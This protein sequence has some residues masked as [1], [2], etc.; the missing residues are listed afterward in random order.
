M[1]GSA[2]RDISRYSATKVKVSQSNCDGKVC[3]SNG[4][5]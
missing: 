5:N 3:L 4:G 1:R 2:T